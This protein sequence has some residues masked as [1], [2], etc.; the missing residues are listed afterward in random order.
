MASKAFLRL[1]LT[2]V[3]GQRHIGLLDAFFAM[4]R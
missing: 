1:S 4:A 3:K 2:L